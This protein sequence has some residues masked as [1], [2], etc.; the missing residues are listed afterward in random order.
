MKI[1]LGMSGGIDSSMCAL[2]LKEQGHEVIGVTMAKWSP[3]S[4]IV[5]A[6]KRGCFCPS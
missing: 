2:M 6:N 1:A 5:Q 3:N 4:G